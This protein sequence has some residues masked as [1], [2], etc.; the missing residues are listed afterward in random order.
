[1]SDEL[2][3][4]P[5]EFMR[6]GVG[7][8]INPNASNATLFD[9]IIAFKHGHAQQ[10]S[11]L[12]PGQVNSGVLDL[13]IGGLGISSSSMLNLFIGGKGQDYNSGVL[14]LFLCNNYITGNYLPLFI[15]GD[16]VNEGYHYSRAD[17]N[18]YLE[19]PTGNVLD[20]VLLGPGIPQSGYLDLFLTGLGTISATLNLVIGAGSGTMS[21]T[22]PLYING[23]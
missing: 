12:G 3:I 7:P 19:R 8:S 10:R 4:K 1:M 15:G 11:F 20:L 17:L 5:E 2:F 14:N 16:G 23:F 18:L 22:L 13:Y 6:F 21:Q 9:T